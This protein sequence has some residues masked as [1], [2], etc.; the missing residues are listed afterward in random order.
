MKD[1]STIVRRPCLNRERTGA[2]HY[3]RSLVCELK[4]R[5]EKLWKR[6]LQKRKKP[7]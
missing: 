5:S 2:R 1:I 7:S 6:N 3:L 4:L